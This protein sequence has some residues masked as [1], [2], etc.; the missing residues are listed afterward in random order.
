MSEGKTAPNLKVLDDSY[1]ILGELRS[2]ERT[3]TYIAKRSADGTDVI[4]TVVDAPQ[5]G[6]NNALNL[7][8]AD[9][10]LLSKLTHAQVPQVIEG[11]WVGKDQF[12][13]V[14]RRHQTSTLDELL[15]RGEKF[16][17]PRVSTILQEVNAILEWARSNGV[18]HRGVSPDS[19]AFESGTNRVLVS[20]EP[21][22]IPMQGVP[23]ACA[24]AKTIGT[25]TW[26]M[27][28][29]T[30]HTDAAALSELRPDL[31]KRVVDE[32]ET[33]VRCKSGGEVPDVQTFLAVIAAADALRAGELEV[34]EIQAELQEARRKELADFE[35][36]QAACALRNRE[37]EEQLANERKE[38]EAK[39]ADEEAQLAQVKADFAALKASE[40]GQLAIERSQFEQE[41]HDLEDARAE[42]ERRVAER[43]AELDGKHAEVDRIRA[44]EGQRIDAAIAAAVETVAATAVVVPPPEDDGIGDDWKTEAASG[45][46]P[47][48][49]PAAKP[50]PAPW[51]DETVKKHSVGKGEPAVAMAGAGEG[52]RPAWMIPAGATA[53]ILL[54]VAIFALTN[55]GSSAAPNNVTVGSSKV[56]PTAPTTDVRNQPKGGFLTQTAG[57]SVAAPVGPPLAPTTAT[58]A[59]V[60][61][62]STGKLAEAKPS[63][64][65]PSA[66]LDASK[67]KPKPKPKPVERSTTADSSRSGSSFSAEADA[68]RRAEAARRDSV[69]R[70][71]LARR[72]TTVRPKPDTL[73][74]PRI[75]TTAAASRV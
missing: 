23:D 56:I 39:M 65:P 33:M 36:E 59:A 19:L 70:D 71:S 31:A 1:E 67:P 22:P 32:T 21:T 61:P 26:S 29:G 40:E 57:G 49:K 50:D 37:L 7:F 27:L 60:M 8:A 47:A 25:L 73:A 62:D 6:E 52:G 46:T 43:E 72:D 16:S 69:R 55:R 74:R 53:L 38:F 75:D 45:S 20:L 68:I 58:P 64:A 24:D 11:R 30:R 35:A 2:G 51:I 10:Q 44:E 28:T 18:V 17:P 15:A 13:V 14:S 12:A 63:A 48:T 5:G 9:T 34:A 66:A 42:F 3:G 4:I 54:L 41:R